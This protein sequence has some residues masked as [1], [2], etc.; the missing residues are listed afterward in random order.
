MNV[1]V[2]HAP[3]HT[4]EQVREILR[5][6]VE[7][8]DEF[9]LQAHKWTPIFIQAVQMLGARASVPLIEQPPPLLPPH[10]AIPRSNR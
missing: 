5:E 3:V 1:E 4:A 9:E 6:A 8:A 2:V 7:I 10:M